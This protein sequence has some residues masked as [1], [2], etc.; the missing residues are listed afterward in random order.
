[1]S[2]QVISGTPDAGRVYRRY[3]RGP[4]APGIVTD[5]CIWLL[6][7]G[8]AVFS[9]WYPDYAERKAGLARSA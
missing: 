7:F 5:I 9:A 1:M 8:G 4:A 2:W 3:S 6:I